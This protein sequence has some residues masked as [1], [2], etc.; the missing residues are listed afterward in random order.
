MDRWLAIVEFQPSGFE[1]GTYVNVAAMWLWHVRD[2]FTFHS[3]ERISGLIPYQGEG[4][5][6]SAIA[7]LTETARRRVTELRT[8]L[9]SLEG[10]LERLKAEE[11]PSSWLDQG[12]ALGLLQRPN[13]ARASF[14]RVLVVEDD[15]PWAIRE[16]NRIS[17]L[18]GLLDTPGA[19]DAHIEQS[20]RDSRERLGLDPSIPLDLH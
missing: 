10:L 11:T 12:I 18:R 8:G 1:K 20:I 6:G 7:G 5:F 15:R 9:A 16:R 13:E 14:D 4:S 19:F 17:N 2:E 3:V